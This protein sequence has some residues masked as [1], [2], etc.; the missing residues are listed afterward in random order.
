MAVEIAA[1]K[2][3]EI[4]IKDMD[5]NERRFTI[6]RIP[7]TKARTIVLEYTYTITPKIGDAQAN[8]SIARE[9]LKYASVEIDDA[10]TPLDS[11]VLID[12]YVGDMD[13]LAKLEYALLDY[14]TSFLVHGK[15]LITSVL[16]Q[17]VQDVLSIGVSMVSSEPSS[18]QTKQHT[19]N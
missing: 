16:S 7:A 9:L 4:I 2:P 18:T 6:H 1:I 19:E 17:I 13:T 14:N 5:D 15:G 11:D 10:L 3:Q 8:L 12:T